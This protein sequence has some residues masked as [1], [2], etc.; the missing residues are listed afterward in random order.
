[1]RNR[2]GVGERANPRRHWDQGRVVYHLDP[3][4]KLHGSVRH[5]APTK[6]N[7]PAVRGGSDGGPAR[8]RA[9]L[10]KLLAFGLGFCVISTASLTIR[11]HVISTANLVLHLPVEPFEFPSR[12]MRVEYYM[13][14]WNNKTL[15]RSD[16]PCEEIKHRN[17]Q[18]ESRAFDVLW[19]LGFLDRFVK[20]HDDW[21]TREYLVHLHRVLAANET[22]VALDSDRSVI[23]HLGDHHS[24][25]TT[26]PVVAKSRFSRFAV[27]KQS[28]EKFFSTIIWPL[29]MERHYD[30]VDDYLNLQRE[31]KVLKWE[32][33]RDALIWRGSVTG[34]RSDKTLVKN[35]PDGGSRISVVTRY[36]AKRPLADVAFR[37]DDISNRTLRQYNVGK[38]QYNLGQLVRNTDTTMEDQ[39]KYKYILMLEGNDVASGLKWQL[40]SNSVVFM[41]RPT[42]VSFAMED[43]LVPFV[44]YVPLK[45][46]YSDLEEMIIWARKN[47]A[48]C[49]WI[50]EQATRYMERLWVSDEAKEENR[51]IMCDLGEAYHKQ[52]GAA[53]R[54]CRMQMQEEFEQEEF[55]LKSIM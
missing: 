13:G 32:N 18:P 11:L 3:V 35:H 28:G 12:A 38:W 19:E 47:D 24:Q 22:S 46:D 36:F 16:L 54:S 27:S 21:R 51:L 41:A 17:I 43:V 23:F 53:I 25:S 39:L 29:G 44:H 49:K 30:P 55:D 15:G 45:E 33:K 6:R 5:G 42:C 48:K 50:S 20:S 34:I 7:T 2:G 14:D 26:L 31:G 52:F 40:L 10:F 9:L 1:M 8:R 4:P 37:D